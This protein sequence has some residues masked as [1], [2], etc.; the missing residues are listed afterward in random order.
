[1]SATATATAGKARFVP[2][3]ENRAQ[4]MKKEP[5]SGLGKLNLD[6]KNRLLPEWLPRCA[7]AAYLCA[8][9]TMRRFSTAQ[10]AQLACNGF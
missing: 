9:D 1:M 5:M 3:F 2:D 6:S 4:S 8:F 10:A 7:C